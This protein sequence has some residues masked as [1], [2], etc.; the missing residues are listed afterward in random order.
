MEDRESKTH[1][2]VIA[3]KN[4]SEE[5]EVNFVYSQILKEVDDSEKKK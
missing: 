5:E 1:P 3:T 4:L 2:D